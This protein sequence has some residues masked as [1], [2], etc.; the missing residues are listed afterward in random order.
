MLLV[1]GGDEGIDLTTP[2]FYYIIYKTI[3]YRD[4]K[5]TMD[6]VINDKM[7]ILKPKNM[8]KKK[9]SWKKSNF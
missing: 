6:Q 5:E 9:I 7:K 1:W 2:I 3:T 8:K 4:E